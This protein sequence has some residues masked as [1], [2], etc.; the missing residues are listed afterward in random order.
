MVQETLKILPV[1]EVMGQ[2]KNTP[3]K[4]VLALFFLSSYSQPDSFGTAL[5]ILNADNQFRYLEPMRAP[6]SISY[7]WCKMNTSQ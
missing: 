3:S 5:F 4:C 1:V 2:V 7:F 6:P